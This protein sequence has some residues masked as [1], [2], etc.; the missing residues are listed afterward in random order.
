LSEAE[1]LQ[2][3]LFESVVIL[4][5][6]F[7]GFCGCGLFY[8]GFTILLREFRVRQT[9]TISLPIDPSRE[10]LGAHL[11]ITREGVAEPLTAEGA[12]FIA[13]CHHNRP[14]MIDFRRRLIGLIETLA[15]SETPQAKV[16]LQEL[17]AFPYDLPDLATKR[18]SGGNARPSGIAESCFER[19]QSGEL[20]DVY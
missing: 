11:R 3:L 18:P 16:A 20:P 19:R 12:Q 6:C 17:L 14:A 15:G 9:V 7:D 10:S 4:A 13:I 2:G 8:N 1:H 5:A